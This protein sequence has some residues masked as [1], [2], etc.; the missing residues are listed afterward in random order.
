MLLLLARS[1]LALNAHATFI[2]PWVNAGFF[3]FHLS[4]DPTQPR[5]WTSWNHH[6]L[7]SIIPWNLGTALALSG[8]NSKRASRVSTPHCIPNIYGKRRDKILYPPS[9]LPTEETGSRNLLSCFTSEIR[10]LLVTTVMNLIPAS[11]STFLNFL[12]EGPQP[13]VPSILYQWPEW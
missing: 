5:N 3:S 13:L 1:Q 4:T 2:V 8:L 9:W 10:S 11:T 12:R 7:D 6:L